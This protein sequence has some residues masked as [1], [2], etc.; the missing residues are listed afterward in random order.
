MNDENF[1]KPL[2]FYNNFVLPI[3]FD[4]DLD[5]YQKLLKIQ[6]KLNELIEYVN[7]TTNGWKDYTDEQI[8]ILKNYVDKQDVLY[9]NMLNKQINDAVNAMQDDLR[10]LKLYTDS[11]I[12]KLKVYINNEITGLEAEFNLKLEIFM[13][14]VKKMLE[15][16]TVIC[17]NPTNGLYEKTCKIIQDIYEKLRYQAV[18][19]LEFDASGVT[20]KQFDDIGMDATTF[21]LYSKVKLKLQWCECIMINPFTGL[22]DSII[23]VIQQ[24]ITFSS[25][26]LTSSAFDSR[27][28]IT[29][30]YF[31]SKSLTC[32]QY[33]FDGATLL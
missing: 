5:S 32:T 29:C 11:E 7:G 1:I 26:A 3:Y 10:N 23:N 21:D 31:D 18:T 2:C 22:K 30:S 15:E 25:N 13:N 14:K 17:F 6:L 9:Y 19:A 12:A 8:A 16:Y 24:A 33:D 28:E 27:A 4:D 20:A